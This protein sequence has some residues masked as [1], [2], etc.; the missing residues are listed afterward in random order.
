MDLGLAHV[1]RATAR[2]AT[3]TEVKKIILRAGSRVDR[4]SMERTR[5]V[6]P[7][8][9]A[10]G[11]AVFLAACSSSSGGITPSGVT[12]AAQLRLTQNATHAAGQQYVYVSDWN[13]GNV[14]TYAIDAKSG[15]L[16]SLGLSV[17]AGTEPQ[18]VTIDPTGKFAYVANFGTNNVSA[19]T[20]DAASGALTPVAG[21]PFA[22]GTAP[23]GATTDPKGKFVYV[24][25]SGSDDVY[26]F[27]IDASSGA[28]TPVAGSPYTVAGSAL[29]V[30]VDPKGKFAYVAYANASGAGDVAGYTINGSTGALKPVAGSPFSTGS[31]PGWMTADPNDKYLYVSN[32]ISN[33]ISGFA[34]DAKSG[35]LTPVPKSPF[36]AGDFPYSVI[37]DPTGKFLYEVNVNSFTISAYTIGAGGL[38]PVKGS[39][40]ATGL[41]PESVAVDATGSFVY[42]A[43]FGTNYFAT[44]NVVGYKIDKTTG[45]LTRLKGSPYAQ[46]VHSGVATCE[47]VGNACKPP[48]PL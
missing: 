29:W 36:A 13:T 9:S 12:P 32:S 2:L 20:I 34:I 7:I 31:S 30:A 3:S 22:V 4:F 35:A 47:R 26:A 27:A 24:A 41:S 43:D 14:D 40:F 18:P 23:D 38:K 8:I 48:L 10:L 16:K 15:A 42:V 17:T 21:S 5:F 39:P 6:I 19:Y 28:L 37:V 45:A 33:D 11:L 1:R 46:G 25:N 44:G